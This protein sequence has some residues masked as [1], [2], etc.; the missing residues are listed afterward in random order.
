VTAVYQNEAFEITT[1]REDGPY[2]DHRHPDYVHFSEKIADDLSRRDFTVNSMAYSPSQGWLDPFGGLRDLKDRVIRAVGNPQ[3]RF[4]EDALRIL[5]GIRF[6]SQF[7]FRVETDTLAAMERL[8]ADLERISRERIRYELN[9]ILLSD[10]PGTGFR[11]LA[12]L[13]LLRWTVPEFVSCVGFDQKSRH[14]HLDV[15]EHS[16]CVVENCPKDLITRL[17]ALFHD[18]GKPDC[19]STDT[20]GHGHFYGHERLGANMAEQIMGG[21]K[22]DRTTVQAVRSLVL[23]HMAHLSAPGD[24]YVK[25]LLV[26]LGK[27]NMRRLF[28]LQKA[29]ILASRPP[30]DF[31]PIE[32]LKATA[33]RIVARH[34]PLTLR[35][36]AVGGRDLIAWDIAPRDRG[37]ILNRLLEAVYEEPSLNNRDKLRPLVMAMTKSEDVPDDVPDDVMPDDVMPDDVMQ[38]DAPG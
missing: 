6:S 3:K 16:L 35:D 33:D 14:H 37:K 11:L 10:Q 9:R 22:Y 13:Y 20:Q 38:K 12:S 4:E 8:G 27:D 7:G 26:L 30:H 2:G 29:D 17:A 19:F 24:A 18:I 5:R 28:D 34:D 36:L 23:Y 25:K 21:L 31:S 32:H 15:F 1:F